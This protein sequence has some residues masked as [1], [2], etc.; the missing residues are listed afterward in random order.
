M[1]ASPAWLAELPEN[2]SF[3]RAAALPTAG[4]TALRILRLGPAILGRRILI[5]GASGGVGRFAIQ[6][7]NLGGAEVT[8][9]VG[10]DSSR[11]AGLRQLGADEVVTDLAQLSGRYDLILEDVAGKIALTLG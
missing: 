3:A 8:A 1:A 11:A 2:V 7:A 5:T 10:S 9:L 4:P 6:L